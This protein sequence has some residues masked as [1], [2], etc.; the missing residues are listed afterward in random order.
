MCTMMELIEDDVSRD[1][2]AGID[3]EELVMVST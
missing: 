3:E 1:L 2:Y